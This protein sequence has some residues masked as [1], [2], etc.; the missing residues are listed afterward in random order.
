M[1]EIAFQERNAKLC[2]G[3]RWVKTKGAAW[4]L[5]Q[6][7]EQ[8]AD[9]NISVFQAKASAFPHD[10]DMWIGVYSFDDTRS[11]E[12]RGYLPDIMD[13]LE[14]ITGVAPQA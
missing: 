6:G 8:E 10:N 4:F 3:W 7:A 9:D 2:N 12:K 1:D 11:V 14:A 13:F 5:F